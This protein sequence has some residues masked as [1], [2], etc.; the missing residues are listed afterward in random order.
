MPI[1]WRGG[2]VGERKNPGAVTPHD[3]C[4]R[5]RELR[6]TRRGCVILTNIYSGC[7]RR[8]G[9][10]DGS[11]VGRFRHASPASR[12]SCRPENHLMFSVQN[13]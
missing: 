13:K 7:A 6:A 12:Q 9:A 8:G 4:L 10:G 5:C 11:N 1:C 2:A 3:R